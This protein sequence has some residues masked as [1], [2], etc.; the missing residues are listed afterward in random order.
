LRVEGIGLPGLLSLLADAGCGEFIEVELVEGGQR[1]GFSFGQ[2]FLPDKQFGGE[3]AVDDGGI[4][5][6]ERCGER[7]GFGDAVG[8]V[9]LEGGGDELAPGHGGHHAA[10]GKAGEK[11]LEC[12]DLIR[13]VLFAGGGLERGAVGWRGGFGLSGGLG[14]RRGGLREGERETQEP[15]EKRTHKSIIAQARGRPC[16]NGHECPVDLESDEIQFGK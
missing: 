6:G 3:E 10:V 7:G 4:V 11:L 15:E 5:G 16:R 13:R 12:R 9:L 8:G 2:E 1:G 14:R